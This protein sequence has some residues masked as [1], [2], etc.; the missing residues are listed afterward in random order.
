MILLHETATRYSI[1]IA[2]ARNAKGLLGGALAL[3]ALAGCTA[4]IQGAPDRLVPIAAET[5]L[6]KKLASPEW[7]HEYATATG[8]RR[9]EL[10]DQ[11]VLARMYAMDLYYSEYEARLTGKYVLDRASRIKDNR[12]S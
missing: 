6:I 12:L 3:L 7:Y 2:F 1:G 10:R 9:R 5:D 4:S 8:S 11:I